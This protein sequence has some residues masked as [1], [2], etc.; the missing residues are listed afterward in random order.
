MAMST[1]KSDVGNSPD[2]N[3]LS[4]RIAFLQRFKNALVTQRERFQAY[5]DIL[6]RGEGSTGSPDEILEFHVALEEAVV[7]DIALFEQTIR[8]LEA[9]YEAGHADDDPPSDIPRIREALTRTREELVARS[10]MNRAELRR[11]IEELTSVE[12][13]THAPAPIRSRR[14][15]GYYRSAPTKATAKLVDV[16]A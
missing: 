9:I 2:Q 13:V 15:S 3:E 12:A 8:P 4:E 11:Q 7:R 5:L 6:E 16:N 1:A 14:T 10:R